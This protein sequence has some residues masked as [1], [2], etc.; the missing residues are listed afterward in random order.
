MILCVVVLGTVSSIYAST[1]VQP[2]FD[3]NQY[4]FNNSVGY[5]YG[6]VSDNAVSATEVS[7]NDAK[8][9]VNYKGSTSGESFRA[10]F[11]IYNAREYY[12]GS[13]NILS[14]GATFTKFPSRVQYR[15]NYPYTLQASREHIVNPSKN[16]N[17]TWGFGRN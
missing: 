4:G 7:T 2:R 17:G 16:V 6:N 3:N 5:N 8:Y 14:K 9:S 1:A 15:K 13:S 10:W 11:R 12:S